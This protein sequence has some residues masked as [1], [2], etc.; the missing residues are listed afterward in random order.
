MHMRRFIGPFLALVMM[1]AAFV[2]AP[3]AAS[4]ASVHTDTAVT[5]STPMTGGW[6]IAPHNSIDGV[7]STTSDFTC[8]WFS[9]SPF[10]IVDFVCQVRAG[11]IRVYIICLNGQ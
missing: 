5:S 2:V 4:A 3:A 9:R 7:S 8:N 6:N 10:Q 1:L 11:V